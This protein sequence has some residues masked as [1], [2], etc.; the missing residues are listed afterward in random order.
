MRPIVCAQLLDNVFE[1]KDDSVFRD[2]Q[3]IGDLFVL[4]AVPDKLQH[5]ELARCEILFTQMLCD[6]SCDC[7][8]NV[9]F[10]RMNGSNHSQQ[11]ILGHAFENV[12]RRS[13]T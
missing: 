3:L 8:W 6:K 4:V 12:A 11:V 5:L 10:A 13:R 9:P 7:W 2:R 1:M